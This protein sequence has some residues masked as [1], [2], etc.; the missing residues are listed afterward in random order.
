MRDFML[1]INGFTIGRHDWGVEGRNYW[2]EQRL[3]RRFIFIWNPSVFTMK[4][5]SFAGLV[6]AESGRFLTQAIENDEFC[7]KNEELCIE[8]NW[9]I[10][11]GWLKRDRKMGDVDG[12]G[13]ILYWLSLLCDCFAT[14]LRRFYGCLLGSI[15]TRDLRDK[16]GQND[17]FCILKWWILY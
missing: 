9:W 2:R 4:S 5:I 10:V 15:L 12:D 11:A 1:K 8:Q 6:W 3:P 13:A 16:H 17:E 7:I 14:V